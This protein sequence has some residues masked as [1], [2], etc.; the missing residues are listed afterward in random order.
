MSDDDD[1]GW[2]W[3]QRIFLRHA[4]MLPSRFRSPMPQYLAA[5]DWCFVDGWH[6]A[7]CASLC[8]CVCLALICAHSS[9]SSSFVRRSV[10]K[11]NK[12]RAAW[13]RCIRVAL[14]TSKR[15]GFI[16]SPNP[17][18]RKNEMAEKPQKKCVVAILL[19]FSIRR[20][21]RC[22]APFL[23]IFSFLFHARRWCWCWGV[24]CRLP[25]LGRSRCV[26]PK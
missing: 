18:K 21:C 3:R 22:L 13:G 20:C 10:R 1:D 15:V 19:R 17:K 14:I 25:S 5:K 8:V 4:K 6:A 23:C 16:A 11:R 24:D 2:R 9:P 26:R 12:K 7:F